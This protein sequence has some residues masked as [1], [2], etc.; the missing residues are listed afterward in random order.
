LLA[1]ASPSRCLDAQRARDP[2]ALAALRDI[3]T[4][5]CKNFD[6]LKENI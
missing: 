1:L 2:E 5:T 6:V 4:N 3:D